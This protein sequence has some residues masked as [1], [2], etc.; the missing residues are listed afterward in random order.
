MTQANSASRTF[1]RAAPQCPTGPR[2][3]EACSGIKGS[4]HR[5]PAT[6]DKRSDDGSA[7]LSKGSCTKLKR[8]LAI[9]DTRVHESMCLYHEITQ[10]CIVNWTKS[11]V[12]PP[13]VCGAR[14]AREMDHGEE[15]GLRENIHL[16]DRVSVG[17]DI[18]LWPA[19]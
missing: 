15:I 13:G 10:R 9:W 3:H 19:S 6:I 17:T 18:P 7:G 12:F 16:F 11:S 8:L 5:Q 2:A 1:N 14:R 4:G